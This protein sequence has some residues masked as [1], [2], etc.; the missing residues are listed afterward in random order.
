MQRIEFG[1]AG[2]PRPGR[3]ASLIRE[4]MNTGGNPL[5]DEF[6]TSGRGF[7]KTAHPRSLSCSPATATSSIALGA[8]VPRQGSSGL[9]VQRRRA[10]RV[11][12]RRELAA[13]RGVVARSGID[14]IY[15]SERSSVSSRSPGVIQDTLDR[16]AP[17]SRS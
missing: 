2:N 6:N 9:R 10:R 5:P 1:V 4:R 3:H 15:T 11:R 16:P 8:A 14:A 17:E 7:R 12:A 13:L